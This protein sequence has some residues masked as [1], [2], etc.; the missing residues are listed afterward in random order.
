MKPRLLRLPAP[1]AG[2]WH[3]QRRPR[4][5]PVHWRPLT[6]PEG[7]T[8]Y[9]R[10]QDTVLVLS[11]RGLPHQLWRCRQGEHIYVPA[12]LED[13]ARQ[14]LAHFHEERQRPP[15][16]RDLPP[17]LHARCRL[18]ARPLLLLVLWHGLRAGW[19][20]LPDGLPLP[21]LWEQAGAL[22]NVRLRVYGEWQRLFT[23]LT[24]HADAGHLLGNV[25][26]GGI[27]L[28]L[29]ARLT[30]PGRALL[31]T[32]LGG[33]LGNGL[34]VLLRRQ[35]VLSLGFSTALFAAVGALAGYMVLHHESKRYLPLVAGVGILAMWGMGEGNVDYLAHVCGLAAG[36]VLGLW[37]ALRGARRW[38][39]LP[40][41][42][43]ALLAL[44]LPVLAWWQAFRLL[45]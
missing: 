39:G 3:V 41:W 37:E 10:R 40:Q 42:P 5:L 16:P 12:L 6:G 11:A 35:F 38:P 31:L 28:P 32:I 1:F 43:A 26:L 13:L 17:P 36:M 19:C 2:L 27:M 15:A 22:D 30:G 45:G 24:L 29:L 23:A 18:A 44:A 20:P 34:T 14:E 21:A 4:P 7:L 33:G 8:S 25:L 9:R